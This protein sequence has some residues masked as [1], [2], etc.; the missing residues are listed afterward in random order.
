MLETLGLRVAFDG[1]VLVDGV[2]LVARA[3][4]VTAILGANG[5]GKSTLFHAIAG[6]IIPTAGEVRMFGRPVRDWPAREAARQRAVLAQN[7][8]LGFDFLV[9]EAV[10]L[11][12]IPHE[13]DEASDRRIA[14]ATLAAVGLA[15]FADRRY[16]SLSGGEK[17]RVHLARALA[18]VWDQPGGQRCLL[19]DEPTVNLD[20]TQKRAILD[21]A[22]RF[23][24]D[25]ATVLV[26]LHE[27]NLA[28]QF[29]D[30]LVLLKHGRVVAQGDA[31]AVLTQAHIEHA[32]EGSARLLTDPDTGLPIV[33]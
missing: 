12:R 29:A 8:A 19:L 33:L 32:Y 17:Q 10:A 21:T 31:H 14:D 6:G 27:L 15:A 18:Q 1:M 13:T 7:P 5:A 3:G 24:R 16:L 26:V 30:H 22:R 4:A 20:F 2:S 11:G 23:A 9:R 25:G 28:A